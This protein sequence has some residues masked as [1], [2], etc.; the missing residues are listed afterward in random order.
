MTITPPQVG[1]Y[2]DFNYEYI[3]RVP[4]SDVL[5]FMK[6]QFAESMSLLRGLSQE[7]TEMRPAPGEWTIKQIVGHMSD[8]ERIFAYRAMRIARGDETPLPGFD[9]EPYV[10][11][12]N[13]DQRNLTDLLDEFAAIRHSN[14]Y[15]FSNFTSEDAQRLGTASNHPISVRSLIYMCAGHEHHHMESIRKVYLKMSE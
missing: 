6:T 8:T 9:Q 7:Q 1:E 4:A 12:G 13:F 15:L 3:R 10:A 11:N 14:L 2:S 5:V